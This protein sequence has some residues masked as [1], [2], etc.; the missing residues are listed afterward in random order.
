[1]EEYFRIDSLGAT[2]PGKLLLSVEDERAEALLKSLTRFSGGRYETGLLW[3]YANVRLPDSRSMALRRHRC[4][5]KR[6]ANDPQLAEVLQQKIDEYVTKGYIRRLS[7]NEVHQQSN[8][9][10]FLPIF[11]VVN[12]NKPGKIRIVWDAAAKVHGTSL[13]SA[14]LKGPDLL[15]SLLEILLR[16]RLYSV[17]VTG[18][19]REMF[20]QVK[21]RRED[22]EYQ[23]FYWTDRDGKTVIY[24]M[25][26][27]TFGACCSPSSAQYVKNINAERYREEFPSAC[28]AI[29]KSHYVDDM[30]ISVDTE[31]E[32]I[33]VAEDVRHVH[34]QGGFEF[35]NWISNSKKVVASLQDQNAK[36]EKSLNRS[37]EFA[38]EKVLG[39]WRNTTIDA[40]TFK[41][42]WD[43]HDTALLKGSRRPTKRVVLRML[44]TIFDPLGLIAHFLSFMKALL[45]QVWRSGISWDDEVDND[46]FEKWQKWLSFL[47]LVEQLQIP[48]CFWPENS[49]KEADGIQLHTF[50]DAGKS[51][52]AAVCYLRIQK[53]EIIYC[54]LISGK[55]R[56]APLKL[57]SIPR[58]ELQAAVIGTR[59][60]K[61]VFD[62]LSVRKIKRFYWS[63]SRDVLCWINS[64]HRRYSQFVGFR[65]TEILE[66]TEPCDWRYVPS[67]MNVA[68][69]ATKWHGLPDLSNESR[70]FR[71]PRFLYEDVDKWPVFCKR[72]DSTNTEL[73][74][75]LLVHH[76]S[77]AQVIWVQNFSNWKRLQRVTA[78][79]HRFIKNC[80]H[81]SKK[82]EFKRGILTSQELSAAEALLLRIAQQ[83]GYPEEHRILQVHQAETPTKAVSK[84][85]TLYTLSPWL[86]E[87]GIMR[88]KTRIAACQY[89]S[90]D[91]KNPIILPRR[92]HITTLIIHHYH[93]NYHHQNHETVI[94]ELR[95]KYQIP[96]LRT[97]YNQV[98]RN[99][100]K[101]KNDQSTPKVP[102]MADLPPGRLA[103]F[104]RPFTHAGVDYFG[105]IEVVVGR[106]T[107]KR[108][109]MLVTCLTI[110][111]IHI[112]VVNSLSTDSCVMAL[113]NFAARR[114]Q[115]RKIYSD[116]GTNF[117]GANKELQKLDAIV[118]QS[119]I[120]REFTTTETEWVFNS[121]MAPHMGGS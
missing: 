80:R 61:T 117:V 5:E 110:R 63:D 3:R 120:M 60:S 78:L 26:V 32:A 54:S 89:A 16:F 47:P 75:S 50:V 52:M 53:N 112:E 13:N 109:G 8:D 43:R 93:D 114:G 24:V 81:Q 65:V 14:L 28:D 111:A 22:Q 76:T 55:A 27:M 106:R 51:G 79:V 15:C 69:D 42:G 70:W 72:I 84:S 49:I 23:C 121:P 67:K 48:R 104:S 57:T 1:M 98:R 86:D 44:M 94:N 11:P 105:P 30:L 40:F 118:N 90:E 19:I 56:V 82:K 71:G 73:L 85:S 18:D 107:E 21:I 35:R 101:C 59:L 88:M 2:S 4:L 36:E 7:S 68:D 66:S 97:C 99:C 34:A 74:T 95:Q 91:A 17:A 64:D 33:Q 38:I 31:E 108:W 119:E 9:V 29:V 92:H 10:W 87:R 46:V 83:E 45:Q 62:S 12:A 6:M 102:M 96:R 115:P 116:R 20:H 37:A 58:L 25:T 39:M 113:R 100:Q 77:P 103:A 41:I